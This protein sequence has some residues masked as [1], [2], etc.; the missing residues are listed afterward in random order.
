MS[1]HQYV[2]VC[3]WI[4]AH[5]RDDK[6]SGVKEP[7]SVVHIITHLTPSHLIPADPIASAAP[8]ELV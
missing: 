8:G 5:I 3:V 4:A 6:A 7:L 2:S 1:T